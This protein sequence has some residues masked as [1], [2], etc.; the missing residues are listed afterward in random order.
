MA[1]ETGLEEIALENLQ[2]SKARLRGDR[3]LPTREEVLTVMVNAVR[4]KQKLAPIT[5][6]G[7]LAKEARPL[8]D[9]K[10]DALIANGFLQV[11][12]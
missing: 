2:A 9:A 3:E 6:V 1:Y 7:N 12:E 8:W 5:D 4:L 10:I 11:K